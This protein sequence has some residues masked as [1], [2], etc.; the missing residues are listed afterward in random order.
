MSKAAKKVERLIK[1]AFPSYRLKKEYYVFYQN[2]RL[3][4]DYY[5]PE[6]NLVIEVQGEQHFTFNNFYHTD[7][8]DLLDQVVRDRLK[9]QWVSEKEFKLL[10]LT[11]KE[12]SELTEESIR[13][14]IVK[15]V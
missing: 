9:T 12:V 2:T 5:L 14:I 11:E 7:K 15:L 1:K 6:L 3:F 8:N 13:S 4:F 10:T